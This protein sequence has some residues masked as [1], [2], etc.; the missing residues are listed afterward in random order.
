LLGVGGHDLD[1]LVVLPDVDTTGLESSVT[2]AVHVPGGDE[3]RPHGVSVGESL[4]LLLSGVVPEAN[5]T[6]TDSVEGIIVGLLGVRDTV[7]DVLVT[8]GSVDGHLASN[9]EN[10]DV[11]V[12][13]TIDGS[14]EFLVA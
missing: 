4:L 3:V 1:G 2:G 5:V 6:L 9:L 10:P 14:D 7:D 12:S 8:L 11:V 13:G